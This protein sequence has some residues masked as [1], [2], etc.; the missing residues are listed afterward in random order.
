MLTRAWSGGD[1]EGEE[2]GAGEEVGE[3]WGVDGGEAD[4]ARGERR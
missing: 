2:L 3:R 4:D 1:G